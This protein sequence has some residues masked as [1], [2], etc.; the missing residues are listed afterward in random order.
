MG[1]RTEVHLSHRPRRR[2][3]YDLRVLDN[4]TVEV[5][6]PGVECRRFGQKDI[7]DSEK[8]K[9]RSKG[10]FSGALVGTGV[11]G[12]HDD[13]DGGSSSFGEVVPAPTGR[14]MTPA[15][16]GSSRSSGSMKWIN[17]TPIAGIGGQNQ[18]DTLPVLGISKPDEKTND[19]IADPPFVVGNRVKFA[20]GLKELRETVF[21]SGM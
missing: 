5:K 4:S 21:D 15:K 8:R 11:N 19:V 16:F 20:V 6:H 7:A 3:A 17:P 1:F 13:E 2:L 14:E 18:P 12:I 10:F 9:I